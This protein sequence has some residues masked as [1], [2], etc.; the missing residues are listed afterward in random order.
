MI[1]HQVAV[2]AVLMNIQL[3]LIARLQHRIVK[4]LRAGE[5]SDGVAGSVEQQRRRQ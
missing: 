4:G 3:A 2:F 1:K 5:R